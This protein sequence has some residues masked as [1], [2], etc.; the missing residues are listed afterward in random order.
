[1]K[2]TTLR[3][4]KPPRTGGLRTLWRSL[5][6]L[7]RYWPFVTGAY[8]SLL[9]IDAFAMVNPQLIRLIVDRGIGGKDPALLGLLVLALLGLT[10]VKGVLNFLQGRWV[11]TASPGGGLRPAQ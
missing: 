11:E 2:T 5:G 1:M 10:L 6:Y 7:L 9:C 8:L 4:G 3:P